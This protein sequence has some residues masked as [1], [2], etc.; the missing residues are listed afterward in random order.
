[1][2][3]LSIITVNLNN[4][5]GLNKTIESVIVQD[6]SDFEFIIIDGGSIDGSREIIEHYSDKINFW[7]SEPDSGVYQAMNKG[8]ANAKGK[9]LLFLNSGDF[10]ADQFVLKKV[11]SIENTAD[12]LAGKC[13]ITK[14]G[15][16]V[17]ITNPPEEITFGYLYNKGLNHQSTFIKKSLFDKYGLY[18]RISSTIRI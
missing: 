14:N 4:Q 6:F 15:K 8:I 1:M 18:R 16:V 3:K 9:Y 13:N 11:F 17:H 10:L 7:T 12:I 2:N 5:E